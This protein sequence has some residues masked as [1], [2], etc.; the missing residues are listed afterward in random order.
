LDCSRHAFSSSKRTGTDVAE[1][2]RVI[3]NDRGVLARPRS[4]IARCCF[5]QGTGS[6][7]FG[8]EV[9]VLASITG[10]RR[11]FRDRCA[12]SGST[13]VIDT[14]IR[15]R[16]TNILLLDIPSG[17]IRGRL[18]TN[19]SLTTVSSNSKEVLLTRSRN[20]GVAVALV[21]SGTRVWGGS[22]N[23]I[24]HTSGDFA[25]IIGS[26]NVRCLFAASSRNRRIQTR[27]GKAGVW[28]STNSTC[29]EATTRGT[30][31]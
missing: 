9:S 2:G 31:A 6:A 27:T 5:A 19:G 10:I 26:A 29:T 23:R 20:T 3:A 1:I 13:T 21:R 18:N 28:D 12:N 30:R 11:C 22:T 16:S 7:S 17:R 24:V 14:K 4:N 25:K 8:N 15:T